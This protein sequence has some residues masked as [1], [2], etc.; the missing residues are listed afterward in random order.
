M[1]YMP[2]RPVFFIAIVMVAL[3][4]SCGIFHSMKP[5]LRAFFISPSGN[6][7]ST[8]DKNH[9][10]KTIH[11]LNTAVL[12]PG[13]A[14]FFEGGKV[15][16]G[17]IILAEKMGGNDSLT[18]TI[19]SYGNGL[20]TIDAGIQAALT[21]D[22]MHFVSLK[23]LNLVGA[24]RK[25]GNTQDG[26]VI[27]KSSH[28]AIESIDVAG[29]Q[30]AGILISTSTNINVKNIHAHENGYAGIAI[31]GAYGTKNC[32]NIF[33]ADCIAENNPGDP[34]NMGNHSGNGIVAGYCKNITIDHCVATNNGWDMPRIGNGPVGIWC[35]EADSVLIQHCI[36][37]RN[38]TAKGADDGGGF[39]LDGGVSNSIIQ[40]CL[41]YENQ[42]SG[43][44][45]FQYKGAGPWH[46]NI[47]RYN[48]SEN[49]GAVSAAHAAAYIWNST[50]DETQFSNCQFYNNTIYNTKGAAINYAG[51]AARKDFAFYNNIF[52]AKDD[53][54]TGEKAKDVFL[55]NNWWSLTK[56]GV[57]MP[58]LNINPQFNHPGN[59]TFNIPQTLQ[60][61][62]GYKIPANSPLRT[63]GFDLNNLYGITTGNLDF[64]QQPAPIK[65]IGAS[66]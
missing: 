57:K 8:G 45:I 29:F 54:I 25:T 22:G 41:S 53:I 10:W 23:N 46:D 48:I 5:N 19:S 38:K 16:A 35:Y 40:Y 4:C 59:T 64:N 9:P 14:F 18:V 55:A 20:A 50:D 26:L 43:F 37:Y 65:G 21:L 39:D 6:D 66:F 33:I 11:R 15:F 51:N 31:E 62:D 17:N 63:N 56:M 30:K 49:D 34:T 44:G 13:D 1:L 58:G 27:K 47:I 3:L 24:G 12:Q 61:Y 42:G 7:S 2:K 60:L 32:N 52:V 36:S 28:V